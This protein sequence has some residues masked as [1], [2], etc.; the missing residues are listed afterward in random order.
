[1]YVLYSNRY[2]IIV[3]IVTDTPKSKSQNQQRDSPPNYPQRKEKTN[4]L[5]FVRPLLLERSACLSLAKA[6]GKDEENPK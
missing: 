4:W 6:I 1:M 3:I 5:G 2:V